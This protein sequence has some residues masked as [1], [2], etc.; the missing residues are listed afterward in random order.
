MEGF[1]E[2]G[3][4]LGFEGALYLGVWEVGF[5]YLDQGGRWVRWTMRLSRL[6]AFVEVGLDDWEHE[7]LFGF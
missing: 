2:H 5:V 7:R 6:G 1:C 3:Y 4:E